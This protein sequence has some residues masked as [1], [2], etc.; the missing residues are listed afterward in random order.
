MNEQNQTLES[1]D[2][3]SPAETHFAPEGILDYEDAVERFYQPL[4]RFAFGLTGNQSD[5]A[6]LTQE[7]YRA[8]LLK[9]RQVRETRKLKSWLFTTLYRKFLGQRRHNSRFP[10]VE[11]ET[12]EWEL[13]S[14]DP[15]VERQLDAKTVSAALQALDEKYR[16][17]LVLFYL[18]ELSY[19]EIAAALGLPAGTVMSRL[20]RGKELLRK[21]FEE[22]Q[23]GQFARQLAAVL[24]TSQNRASS[25]VSFQSQNGGSWT[26][27]TR[28]AW[29]GR[30]WE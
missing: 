26:S 25:R 11:V 7:T 23:P 6:D 13:P 19:H 9:G 2:R 1:G 12:A 22:G 29:Q 17:P 14:N 18:Q 24:R 3:L 20:S 8:L 27:G 30:G 16:A 15:N 5:A 4:Y 21:R 28:P 10:E